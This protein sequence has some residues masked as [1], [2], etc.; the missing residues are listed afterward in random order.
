MALE[1]RIGAQTH[2]WT[3]RN[4]FALNNGACGDKLTIWFNNGKWVRVD[5]ASYDPFPPEGKILRRVG[6]RLVSDPLSAILRGYR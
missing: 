2:V 1:D 6:D 3:E 5:E 4:T